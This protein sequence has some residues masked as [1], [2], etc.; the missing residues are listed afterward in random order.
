MKVTIDEFIVLL[1]RLLDE[2]L[3]EGQEK[4]L[5]KRIFSEREASENGEG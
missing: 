5:Y 2:G 4:R 1:L 3:T